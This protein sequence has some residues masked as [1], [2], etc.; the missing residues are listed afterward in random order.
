MPASAMSAA[1]ASSAASVPRRDDAPR[2]SFAMVFFFCRCC[3]CRC[4]AADRARR[5]GARREARHACCRHA[6]RLAVVQTREEGDNMAIEASRHYTFVQIIA[7][8]FYRGYSTCH[9]TI[10][11]RVLASDE[12]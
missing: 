5:T 7:S 11:E 2:Y 6:E 3:R 10:I 8:I 12:Y 1:H 9:T 4:S